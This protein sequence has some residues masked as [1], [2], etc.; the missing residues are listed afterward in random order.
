MGRHPTGKT[1][2]Q[3]LQI[4]TGRHR[5]IIRRKIA[6]QSQREIA[7]AMNMSEARLSVICNSP[8]FLKVYKEM[9]G[10]VEERYVVQQADITGKVN[11]L[12]PVAMGVLE[13]ILK[14]KEVDGMK[15]SLTLKKET[16]LNV[17]DLGGNTGKSKEKGSALDDVI[18]VIKGSFSLAKE[19]IEAERMRNPDKFSRG[20]ESNSIEDEVRTITIPAVESVDVD[21]NDNTLSTAENLENLEFIEE[22]V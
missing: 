10:K 11:E 13:N 21:D 17:L 18:E 9:E 15:V 7:I 2:A 8:L 22:A 6:G 12:Q 1:P 4:I 14:N 19:A 20:T 3:A 5:E 16:A